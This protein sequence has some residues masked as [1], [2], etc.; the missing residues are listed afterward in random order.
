MEFEPVKTPGLAIITMEDELLSI[1]NRQIDLRT[2]LKNVGW[3]SYSV[4]L[5]V[6]SRGGA[7]HFIN[8]PYRIRRTACSSASLSHYNYTKLS[9]TVI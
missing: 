4:T 9:Y 2:S 8:A 1:I 6:G 7:L 5:R 3:V